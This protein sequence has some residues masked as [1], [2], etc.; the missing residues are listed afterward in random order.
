MFRRVFDENMPNG[1]Y[2]IMEEDL[3]AFINGTLVFH[4]IGDELD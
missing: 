4:P 2:V 3:E 1:I